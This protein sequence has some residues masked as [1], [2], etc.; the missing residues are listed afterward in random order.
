MPTPPHLRLDR[1]DGLPESSEART[2]RLTRELATCEEVLRLLE[3]ALRVA[4]RKRSADRPQRGAWQLRVNRLQ[5]HVR[6][7]EERRMAL[8]TELLDVRLGAVTAG[9][10]SLDGRRA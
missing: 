8:S 9:Y 6:A 10:W 2:A 1:A 4:E 3:R 7:F 5:R